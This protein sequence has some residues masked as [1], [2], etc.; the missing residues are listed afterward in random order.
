MHENPIFIND[1]RR[2][3][4][5]GADIFPG[6]FRIALDNLLSRVSAGNH[7]QDVAD[8]NPGPANYRLAAAHDRADVDAIHILNFSVA[9]FRSRR[10]GFDSRHSHGLLTRFGGRGRLVYARGSEAL[11]EPWP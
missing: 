1:A 4:E 2:V 10:C 7:A 6:E 11:S 5:G 3:F 9:P 8:H